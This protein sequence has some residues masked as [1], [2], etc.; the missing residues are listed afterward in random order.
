LAAGSAAN[1]QRLAPLLE[2]T[3]IAYSQGMAGSTRLILSVGRSGQYI[4][5]TLCLAGSSFA[6]GALTRFQH[7]QL[8]GPPSHP[9]ALKR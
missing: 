9:D 8:P 2:M 4:Y 3:A 6:L 7:H 1:T 5:T